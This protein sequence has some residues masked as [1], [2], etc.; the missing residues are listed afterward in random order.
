MLAIHQPHGH[1]GDRGQLRHE[2]GSELPRDRSRQTLSLDASVSRPRRVRG[3]AIPGQP[4][5]TL[6]EEPLQSGARAGEV[7]RVGPVRARRRGPQRLILRVE[8]PPRRRA[9]VPQDGA[10]RDSPGD[11]HRP[12]PRR[13]PAV[14]GAVGVERSGSLGRQPLE[15]ASSFG[16]REH[17]AANF[18][19]VLLVRPPGDH[20]AQPA[21]RG[22]LLP[23]KPAGVKV[24]TNFVE[25]GLE[26]SEHAV[27][28]AADVR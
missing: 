19:A 12:H 20:F 25:L 17:E 22:S 23:A 27:G 15:L 3:V 24:E 10:R 2:R 4:P 21:K 16:E 28:L 13:H 18:F 9:P 1:A 5:L 6:G 26:S 7:G 14:V 11:D 8:H